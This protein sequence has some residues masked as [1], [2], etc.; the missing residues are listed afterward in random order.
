VLVYDRQEAHLE[1]A[2]YQRLRELKN[3]PARTVG[4]SVLP[5]TPVSQLCERILEQ[6]SDESQ[7]KLDALLKTEGALEDE[8]SQFK[9]SD[10]NILKTDPGRTSLESILKEV[11][12]LKRI[13]QIGL[14]LSLFSRSS[15]DRSPLPPTRIN[16][17]TTRTAP[18]PCCDSLHLDCR[19][20]LKGVRRSLTA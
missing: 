2:A 17:T 20:L 18:S 11:Q 8:H 14:P 6:L 19:F 16:R 13:R 15:Q 9:Q 4:A 3:H 12:K 10:F 7:M 1:A 5:S